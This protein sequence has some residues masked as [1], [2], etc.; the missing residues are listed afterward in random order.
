MTIFVFANNASTSLAAAASSGATT[1]TLASA[2]NFPS[3]IPSGFVLP[4]T[5]ND[6]A[7]RQIYEI[8][9]ATAITGTTVT[10]QRG[11]EGTAAQNWGIGDLAFVGLTAGV[12][13]SLAGGNGRPVVGGQCQ[14]QYS[15]ATLIK[16]MPNNGSAVISGGVQFQLPAAGVSAANTGV[17]VNGTGSSNLADS[18]A[19]LVSYNG[20]S[21]ILKFWAV[22]TYSHGQ[23]TTA[24][25]IGVEVIILSGSPMTAETLV[26]GVVTNGSGQFQSG[27]LTRTWYRPQKAMNVTS[28]SA[29]HN[30]SSTSLVELNTEIRNAFFAWAG[31]SIDWRLSGGAEVGATAGAIGTVAVGFDG[32]VPEGT[33]TAVDNAFESGSQPCYGT[34]SQ[35]SVK[36]GLSEG[37]HYLT[38]LACVSS[39]TLTLFAGVPATN[40][41]PALLTVSVN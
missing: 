21:N 5:L 40:N 38:V 35:S 13:T 14:I 31:E 41:Y 4:I 32:T 22:G 16:L 26:G 19:Y 25:N 36:S 17:T 29:A 3:S 2:T 23:D 20:V 12:E 33:G 11:Q 27:L 8:V 1:L 39:S 6:Q 18:T 9:Y 30:T 34:I 15:S 37:P 28:F 7:T 10:V 24:G